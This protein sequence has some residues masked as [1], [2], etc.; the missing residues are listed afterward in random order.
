LAETYTNSDIEILVAT[1]HRDSLDFLIAMFPGRD[2]SKLNILIVNQTTEDK[3]LHSPFP[4]VRVVNSFERGLS[5]SRNL[6]LQHAQGELCIIADDDVVY[7]NDFDIVIADA[8]NRNAEAGVIC[9]KTI[10]TSG[11]PYYP[12]YPNTEKQIIAMQSLVPILSIEVTFKREVI[13][14]LSFNE[15][16]G[17]GA[18][19][20]DAETLFFLRSALHKKVP[21]YYSPQ[22]VVAHAPFSS[23]DDVASDRLIYARMA[24]Y[25]KRF[26]A[27]AYVYLIKF[28]FFLLRKKFIKPGQALQKYITGLKGINDYKECLGTKAD[29]LY[30]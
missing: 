2:L 1:M 3:L 29:T 27:L 20:E 24:G 30:D 21:V 11:Q 28:V 9:F 25:Y 15:L 8:H 22:Y 5:K 4:S 26:G 16:F 12:D 18:R 14:G 19:F 6:A 13:G 7:V 17:L 10:T 23:S